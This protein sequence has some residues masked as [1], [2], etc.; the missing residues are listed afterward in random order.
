MLLSLDLGVSVVSPPRRLSWSVV[1]IE[2]R[3]RRDCLSIGSTRGDGAKRCVVSLP[4]KH[5]KTSVWNKDEMSG[6]YVLLAIVM[7]AWYLAAYRE[8]ETGGVTTSTHEWNASFNQCSLS[9]SSKDLLRW[10]ILNKAFGCFNTR[11][12]MH[13]YPPGVAYSVT[14]GLGPL[15]SQWDFSLR[16]LANANDTLKPH[17]ILCQPVFYQTMEIAIQF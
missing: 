13:P 4:P 16:L 9:S 15:Q 5:A 2:K 17:T 12:K 11:K 10:W 14:L 6:Y 3:G 7:C 1:F 8:G